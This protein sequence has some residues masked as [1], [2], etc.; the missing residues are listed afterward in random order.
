MKKLG[1]VVE[2][3]QDKDSMQEYTTGGSCISWLPMQSMSRCLECGWTDLI[4]VQGLWE[5]RMKWTILILDP[6]PLPAPFIEAAIIFWKCNHFY[7]IAFVV[8]ILLEKVTIRLWGKLA[9]QLEFAWL[10]AKTTTTL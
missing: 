3:I 10:N 1:T 8:N 7:P 9:D 2:W 5:D 4:A 6:R